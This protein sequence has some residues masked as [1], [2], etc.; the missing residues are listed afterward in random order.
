MASP[1]I[2]ISIPQLLLSCT[3][4]AAQKALVEQILMNM[5]AAINTATLTGTFEEYKLDTGQTKSEIRYRSLTELQ[6]SYAAMLA[7]WQQLN[8]LINYNRTGRQFRLVDGKN[9]PGI[10]PYYNGGY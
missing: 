6:K 3:S 7:T 5:L 10:G 9:F 4:L 1:T 2:Y 8:H